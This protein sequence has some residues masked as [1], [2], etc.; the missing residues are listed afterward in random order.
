MPVHEGSNRHC[1][2]GRW[3]CRGG[4]KLAKLRS[5]VNHALGAVRRACRLLT[6]CRRGTSQSRLQQQEFVRALVISTDAIDP[7][8]RG[9]LHSLEG[10][11]CSVALAVPADWPEGGH[12]VEWGADGGIKVAP[13]Q[14][15]GSGDPATL[16]WRGSGLTRLLTEFRPDVVQV[17]GEPWWPIT[18]RALRLAER[19]KIPAVL[20]ASSSVPPSLR[21]A[22]RLRRR[23]SIRA[24]RGFIGINRLALDLL[25]RDRPATPHT[26]IPLHGVSV[27][28]QGRPRSQ[29]AGFDVGFIG[30][31]VPERGADLLI[32]ACARLRGDWSL[33]VVGTGPVQQELES[34]AEKV[35]IGSRVRWLGG[36]PRN[37]L[38]SVWPTLDCV[39]LPART[40]PRWV[41]PVGQALLDAMAQGLPVVGTESGVL[42]EIIGDAGIVVGEDDPDLLGLALERLQKMPDEQARLGAAGRRRV[43]A[44]YVDD[45]IARKTLAF[46]RRVVSGA[47]QEEPVREAP[48]P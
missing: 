10:M 32:R 5:P 9:K 48:T 16:R 18:V 35:G 19:L 1:R 39:V 24:A 25:L 23:R 12:R 41:E 11:G 44:E 43:M 3:P 33:T 2:A 27:P 13:I 42:P 6:P 47:A 4:G 20:A 46:W 22:E 8:Q 30:R 15:R 7:S 34:L 26:V 31:L 38:D 45:A 37:W 36:M 40:T 29:R 21:L 14:V 17:E 28:V